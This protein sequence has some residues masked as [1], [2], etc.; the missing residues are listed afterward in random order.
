MKQELLSVSLRHLVGKVRYRLMRSQAVIK[1]T[2]IVV[3]E[4][5]FNARKNF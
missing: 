2:L 3:K 1:P 4:Q 5:C